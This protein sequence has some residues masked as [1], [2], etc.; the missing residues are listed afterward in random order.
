MR[1]GVGTYLAQNLGSPIQYLHDLSQAYDSFFFLH[2][3][4]VTCQI[5]YS[6]TPSDFCPLHYKSHQSR[7]LLSFIMIC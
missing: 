4:D 6:L 2:L 5:H 7:P 3:S 1:P